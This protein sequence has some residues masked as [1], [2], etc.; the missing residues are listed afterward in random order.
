MVP[1]V[2]VDADGITI[3]GTPRTLLC[4]SLF[5][6]RLPRQE[7][8][9]RLEQVRDSGYHCIDVYLPW[10]FHELAPGE[11]AFEGRRDAAAFLD[12]A[13]EVGLM[14]I[15]RPGPYICSEWDGGGLPAWLGLDPDLRVRQNDAAFLAH[16]RR[17]FDRVMPML[18]A[19][20]HHDGGPVVMVQLENELDF[21]DCSDR[22]GYIAALRDLALEHGI[23]VPLLACAGQGDLQGAT[24]EVD[25]V[26]P[27]FNFYPADDSPDIEP[28]VRHYAELARGRGL[29][30]L[31]TETNRSH[32]TLRRLLASGA[33]F[34]APYLQSSG[35][36]FGFTPATGNWGEPGSFMSHGYDFGGYVSSTGATRAE[37]LEAQVLAQV[38]DTLG[39]RLARSRPADPVTGV[40][41]TAE[42][43]TSSAPSALDLSGG[44]RLLAVPN[45]RDE[46]G[47]A[48]VQLLDGDATF[49][50][51]GGAAP[52]V[53]LDLPLD[54]WGVDATMALASADLVAVAAEPGRLELTF[55][56][57]V[58]VTVV[59][60]GLQEV[61]APSGGPVTSAGDRATATLA[62]PEPGIPAHTF[63]VGTDRSGRRVEVHLRAGTMPGIAGAPERG[64]DQGRTR[65]DTA[66]TDVVVSRVN[67]RTGGPEAHVTYAP[68]APPPL[69]ALGVHRGRGTYATTADLTDVSELLVFGACDVLDLSVGGVV[70]PS[71]ATFGA[72]QRV[73]VTAAQGDT[74]ITA[75]VE[76]WGHPNFD[77]ARLPA[78]HLGGLR[79]LGSVWAV[80]GVR[81]VTALWRVLPEGQWAGSPAPIRA[82]GGWSSTRVGAPVTYER[83]LGLDPGHDHAL[84]L[85]GLREPA[86][87]RVDAGTPRTVTAE[88]PWLL[89]PA[90]SGSSVAVTLPH[91]PSRPALRAQLLR[92]TNVEGWSCGAEPD[93]VL[94]Q[95]AG[96]PPEDG[97]VVDLPLTL[98]PG[99]ELWLDVDVPALTGGHVIE[100]DGDGLRVTA[101]AGGECLGRLWTGGA[102]R[103][104]FTGGDPD[105]LWLPEAWTVHASPLTLAVRGTRGSHSSTLNAIR[106]APAPG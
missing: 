99:A 5:Y 56:S 3:D 36:N 50:V 69:E 15:A 82:L 42:F 57:E 71:S 2:A 81:E 94:T 76:I 88:D 68:G 104:R 93:T 13:A 20:Q 105:R 96:R 35:W 92:V 65:E 86:L 53:L 84:H 91:N 102:G 52:L 51:A 47:T 83:D 14:V 39:P 38:I 30:L 10:N 4:A 73:D 62:A 44:G 37:Y 78:L 66:L 46:A 77:D 23:S 17:W 101:W 85:E 79:G 49:S 19:R 41:L 70:L 9:R 80:R 6:F 90:G 43:P 32:R 1:S 31:V 59:L 21:F 34:I 48:T 95:Y 26:I 54:D 27:A 29:P 98:E 24:G 45:L 61:V 11:W 64:A 12:L 28:E 72:T 106:L 22:A 103:P 100:V 89:L 58:P 63:V 40:R 7:W 55:A 16:V 18:A 25:G 74:V 67:V 33:S 60:R 75:V 97:D 87:V 8:R